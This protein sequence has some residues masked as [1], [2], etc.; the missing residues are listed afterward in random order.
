M[1]LTSGIEQLPFESVGD[2]RAVAP[3][4]P[5][6]DAVMLKARIEAA[7][8]AQGRSV[9]HSPGQKPNDPGQCLDRAKPGGHRDPA[10]LPWVAHLHGD[11]ATARRSTS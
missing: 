4:A 1:I 7:G 6:V 5:A 2:C 3:R 10:E 9:L 11:S 8:T